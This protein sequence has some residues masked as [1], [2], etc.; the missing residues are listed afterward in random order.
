MQMANQYSPSTGDA[1]TGCR[2][3]HSDK[4]AVSDTVIYTQ[5][6]KKKK[7]TSTSLGYIKMLKQKRNREIRGINKI[8]IRGGEK[9]KKLY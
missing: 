7:K 3:S 2:K 8:A 1:F 5:L 9:K 4:Y 6:N